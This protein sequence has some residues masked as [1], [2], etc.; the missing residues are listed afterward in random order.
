MKNINNKETHEHTVNRRKK[1]GAAAIV[2]NTP[3][4]TINTNKRNNNNS[5]YGI[6]HTNET[7]HIRMIDTMCYDANSLQ[8]QY[9]SIQKFLSGIGQKDILF[10][11]NDKQR[12]NTLYEKGYF[13][14][15]FNKSNKQIKLK[16][17]SFLE[18]FEKQI[19]NGNIMDKL[20]VLYLF[21]PMNAIVGGTETLPEPI[22]VH[23]HN[24]KSGG[25]SGY[26]PFRDDDPRR[27]VFSVIVPSYEGVPEYNHGRFVMKI[28]KMES[29]A[30]AYEDES[31]IYKYL[32]ATA[33][34]QHTNHLVQLFASGY[35]KDLGKNQIM[36]KLSANFSKY[37]QNAYFLLMENTYDYMD[38]EKYIEKQLESTEGTWST[39]SMNVSLNN[40][41]KAI[42]AI[43]V[44]LNTFNDKYNFFH[45]DFHSGNVKVKTNNGGNE[46]TYVK[47][48]DF[49]FSVILKNP[50]II[51][52]NISVYGLQ[53]D[54]K[55]MF[56]RITDGNTTTLNL[57]PTDVKQFCYLFDYFRLWLSTIITILRYD[58]EKTQYI[59]DTKY[60]N[61]S[62]E[63]AFLHY[64]NT[65][66]HTTQHG[67]FKWHEHFR[68]SLFYNNIYCNIVTDCK[69]KSTSSNPSQSAP[70]PVQNL[71]ERLNNLEIT[72]EDESSDF[73][74][75]SPSLSQGGGGKKRNK[76]ATMSSYKRLGHHKIR[77]KTDNDRKKNS[78]YTMIRRVVWSLNNR[79]YVLDKHKNFVKIKKKSILF[80][81]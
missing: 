38:F 73:S 44:T 63:S 61:Q 72:S 4:P 40:I 9:Q 69:S 26:T 8:D 29:Y 51:S 65:S 78:S 74:D 45:G 57:H 43:K 2:L 3:T 68:G 22:V 16:Q 15:T 35:M 27:D 39:Q 31:N 7:I 30:Q 76:K 59:L 32:L 21:Y 5:L 28:S 75:L 70:L 77:I 71:A 52:K 81:V 13:S 58:K 19:K 42:N 37:D 47:L 12:I 23:S 55:I 14:R 6:F 53:F 18:L 1:G 67:S 33:D 66:P 24:H 36:S 56:E 41:F 10:N 46:I 48:F 80:S 49:D 11:E 79:Y 17:N 62:P 64:M 34:N 50:P 54:Q 60:T 20:I 25:G